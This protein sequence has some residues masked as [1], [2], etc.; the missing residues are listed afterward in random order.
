MLC[1][2]LSDDPFFNNT[3]DEINTSDDFRKPLWVM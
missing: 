2:A 1:V 3:V